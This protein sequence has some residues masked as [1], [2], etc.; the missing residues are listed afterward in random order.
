LQI[1]SK[2]MSFA[3]KLRQ[4]ILTSRKAK[5]F[6]PP[7]TFQ[8]RRP[9]NITTTTASSS[10]PID[11]VEMES[12]NL[13]NDAVLFRPRKKRKTY[14]H[15]ASEDD[16]DNAITET[17]TSPPVQSLDE[18]ISQASHEAE[19]SVSMAEIFRLRKQRKPRAGVEF[20]ASGSLVRDEDGQLVQQ[21]A[22]A[23]PKEVGIVNR[24][25]TQTGTVGDVN[26]HM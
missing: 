19:G 6:E 18:L 25:T 10:S 21:D 13:P 7:P 23:Q 16:N 5:S 15:R 9:P 26:K 14:K 2:S 20:T 8:P 12:E 17:L 3:S 4:E 11:V 1:E 22:G 24:F